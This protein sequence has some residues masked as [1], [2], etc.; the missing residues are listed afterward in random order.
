MFNEELAVKK[1]PLN[2]LKNKTF[3]ILQPNPNSYT[4]SF[5]KYPC[6]FIPE[7]PRWAIN[8]FTKNND[9]VFDPFAGSGTTLLEAIIH[10]RQAYGTE[11][12]DVAKLIIKAKSLKFRKVDYEKLKKLLKKLN[13]FVLN[14]K[15]K[16]CIPEIHNLNHWFSLK[17][18]NDLGKIA[19]FNKNIKNSKQ[20]CFLNICF[21]SIIKKCSFSDHISPKPY[22]STR[23]PKKEYNVFEEFVKVFNRYLNLLKDFN[24]VKRNQK[25]QLLK[26]DALK[27]KIIKKISLAVASPPYIN[28]FDYVRALRLE[29]LWLGNKKENDL[30]KDKK[31]YIGTEQIN[32][33]TEQRKLDI[34]QDS[35]LLKSCFKEIF[36]IDK[37]RA[38]VVKK[39]FEDMKKNLQ[40]VFKRL[41]FKGHYVIVIGNSNIRKIVIESWNIL[42]D[43]A[44][45]I[46]FKFD[47]VFRYAIRNPHIRIP[48]NG[49]GGEIKYD[50]V[51]CLKKEKE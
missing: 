8:K 6:K 4:H 45:K 34:L 29:N 46:G 28:A 2:N 32:I 13:E 40:S 50:Y 31:K 37:K 24:R 25:I 49:N 18:L 47:Y 5:F 38:L 51:L 39:F 26:G 33:E 10:N 27:F 35:K 16:K 30:K 36:K 3:I 44:K 19:F 41:K 48:R 11:I 23:I 43:I 12:D 22:V 14:E 15:S 42:K 17:N 21:I 1:L 9:V 7:I 20:R